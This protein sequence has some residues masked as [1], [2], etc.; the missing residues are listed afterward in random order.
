MHRSSTATTSPRPTPTNRTISTS[1]SCHRGCSGR[2][3]LREVVTVPEY[4]LVPLQTT[5][6][7]FDDFTQIPEGLRLGPG[8]RPWLRRRLQRHRVSV[9]SGPPARLSSRGTTASWFYGETLEPDTAT[10][11]LEHPASPGTVVRFG[12]LLADGSTHWGAAVPVPVGVS[13]LTGQHPSGRRHRAVGPGAGRRTSVTAGSDL[14]GRTPLRAGRLT[15]VGAAAGTVATGRLLSGLCRVH[16][17]QTGGADRRI[18]GTWQAAAGAGAFRAR[19]SPSRS[20]CRRLR[21]RW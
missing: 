18:D 9:R 6:T 10:L 19:R 21:R 11:V 13:T 20:A 4:F 17:P 15:V 1:A 5:P 7:S 14:G 8:S 16:P 12:A 3:N 2:L